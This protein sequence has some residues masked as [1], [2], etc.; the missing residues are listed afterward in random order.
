M[1]LV[2]SY[3]IFFI[4]NNIKNKNVLI[5]LI[6][7]YGIVPIFGYYSVVMWKDVLY[8]TLVLLLS[9]F[10]YKLVTK[11]CL[12]RSFLV[13]FYFISL[14]CILFRT[15]AI[16]MYFLLTIFTL[17]LYKNN[18]L[19]IFILYSSVILTF[20]TI[21][22]PVFNYFNI[23]RSYSSEYIAIPFQQIARMNFKDVHLSD[24][25][26][27]IIN[28]I[29]DIET[30][31]SVYSPTTF[32]NIKFN[33]NYNRDY[34]DNNK[35]IFL[36]MWAKLCFQHPLIASESY[37]MSVLGYW[38]PLSDLRA[39]E[40]TIVENNIGIKSNPVKIDFFNKYVS[41]MGNL[42]NPVI[43]ILWNISLYT[44]LLLISIYVLLNKKTIK[45]LVCYIPIL[46][47]LI[48]LYVAAPVYNEVRYFFPVFMCS[49]LL[50][51]IPYF[52]ENKK[53]LDSLI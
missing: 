39:Y 20:Y 48:T 19:K 21:K 30:L 15:N 12:N 53:T 6:L 43:K 23:R 3:T 44:W 4:Y 16:Y 22:F 18:K 8:S 7:F 24:N 34:F 51:L 50:F 35:I 31:D 45:Y 2:V 10:C 40:N 42:D 28:N 9:I 5:T 46:G 13:K 26:K 52:D 17:V 36:R 41:F 29:I 33:N 11:K 32:D 25:D 49:S 1:A 38:Y 27:K 14:A 47:N 37:M